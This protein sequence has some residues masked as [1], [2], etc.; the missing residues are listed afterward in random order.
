M[1][2][3][4]SEKKKG[5]SPVSII[6]LIIAVGI[7]CFAGYKLYGILKVY[8]DTDKE[9]DSIRE[10]YTAPAEPA[11][12]KTEEEED[13][14]KEDEK[15]TI[16]PPI[17][18][19]WG[20]LKDVNSDI[21]GWLYI[22]AVPDISYPVC[23]GEDNDFYLHRTFEKK[24][25]FSG[26]IFEDYA[27]SPYFND[28]NTIIYGHNMKNGSMFG[29]LKRL[30]EEET[31][32][33]D[34]YI[35]ILT[36]DGNYRYQIFA[37]FETPYD[38]E[39]YSQFTGSGFIVKEWAEK[40]KKQALTPSDVEVGGDDFYVTLSTCTT[41]SSKR[42]VAIAKL[43]SDERPDKHARRKITSASKKDK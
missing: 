34:P 39:T 24:Q 14:A 20:E 17:Q 31:L 18:V 41:D 28:P 35:W 15:E 38:S 32:T 9:Y 16:K 3:K 8:R 12:E 29:K 21:V 25:L 19:D 43:V 6:V 23:K 42:C 10:K 7:F 2:S 37:V 26:A 11:A 5:F 40:M 22:D 30:K 1:G 13:P 4:K 27:N 33:A 36:P